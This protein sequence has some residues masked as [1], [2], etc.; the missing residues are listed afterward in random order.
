MKSYL[1]QGQSDIQLIQ[2]F[3]DQLPQKSTIVDFEETMMLSSIRA[4]TRLWQAEGRIIAFAFVDDYNNLRFEI[5]DGR[6]SEK[7]ER[8]I[9]EW[10]SR[11][12]GDNDQG[13]V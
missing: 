12:A 9:V 5:E 10:G 7:L 11:A 6:R 13:G 4:R 3:I 2:E 8:E 1:L